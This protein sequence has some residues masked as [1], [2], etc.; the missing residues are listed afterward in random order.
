VLEHPNDKRVYKSLAHG[1]PSARTGA[2]DY[3]AEDPATVVGF[4]GLTI[5]VQAAAA[6][7]SQGSFAR[8]PPPQSLRLYVLIAAFFTT[9]NAARYRFK[10]EELAT[11]EMSVA[12]FLIAHPKGTLVWDT[13]PSLIMPDATGTPTN[14]HIVLPEWA[15]ARPYRSSS[16]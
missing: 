16:P 14:Q 6:G 8:V 1:R 11:L 9:P 4:N 7:R 15:A 3:E 13:A 10:K 12:C 5:A 2:R